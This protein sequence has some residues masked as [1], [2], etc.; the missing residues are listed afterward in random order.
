MDEGQQTLWE[1]VR[2]NKVE[3]KEDQGRRRPE[4]QD[5]KE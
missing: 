5:M 4:E 1:A 3:R 2:Y